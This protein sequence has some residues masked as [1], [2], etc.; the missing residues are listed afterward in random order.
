[1]ARDDKAFVLGDFTVGEAERAKAA[2]GLA[3]VKLDPGDVRHPLLLRIYRELARRMDVESL[4]RY[5]ALDAFVAWKGEAAAAALGS[6]TTI[7]V[8]GAL[9]EVAR[10]TAENATLVIDEATFI[11]LQQTFPRALEQLV[12]Q[13]LLVPT[14]D[15]FAFSLDEIGHFLQAK[16]V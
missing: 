11:V 9:E 8:N 5:D 6:T 1:E 2:Y 3:E 7:V 12:E 4:G 10:V 14:T 16:H 15:G 13:N